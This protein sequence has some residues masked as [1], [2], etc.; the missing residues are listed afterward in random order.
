MMEMPK[1]GPEH[2]KLEP[3]AGIWKCEEKMYP[4]QWDPKGGM[5]TGHVRSHVAAGGFVVTGD[6]EQERDGKKTFQGLS[7]FSYDAQEKCYLLHWWDS[8]GMPAE[9]FR[10]NFEGANLVLIS[11]NP[12]GHFRMTYEFLAPGRH[13][14]KMEI[15][16]DGTT[17]SPM[18][19][20]L[21]SR[22]D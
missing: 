19:E 15:S 8:M 11:K 22:V 20:S 18:F 21:A 17:W 16:Q 6:Y 13:R 2:R 10:G 9:V 4:S 12:M 5:A 3:L 1:P 7:V 14:S